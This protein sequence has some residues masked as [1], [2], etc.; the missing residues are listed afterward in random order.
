MGALGEG[1]GKKKGR[2]RGRDR[3]EV[4]GGSVFEREK[5]FTKHKM[6]FLET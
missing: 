4:G 6:N 5:E 3:E 1:Q 2:E